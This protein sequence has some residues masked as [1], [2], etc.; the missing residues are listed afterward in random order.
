MEKGFI[1]SGP[2]LVNCF[3]LSLFLFIFTL[4]LYM[5]VCFV[6]EVTNAIKSKS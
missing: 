6:I 4:F 5:F 1:A 2:H 3:N